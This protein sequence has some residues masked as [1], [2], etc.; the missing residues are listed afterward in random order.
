MLF[1][2]DKLFLSSSRRDD[3]LFYSG[4]ASNIHHTHHSTMCYSFVSAQ[5]EAFF[6]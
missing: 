3:N 5:D 1:I 6:W 4:A 2:Y